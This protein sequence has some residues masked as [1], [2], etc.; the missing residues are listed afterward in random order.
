MNEQLKNALREVAIEEY[1]N[2]ESLNVNW[3][4]SERFNRKIKAVAVKNGYRTKNIVKRVILIAAVILLLSSTM[5]FSFADVKEKVINF[6]VRDM[7][8]HIEIQY[9]FDEAGDIFSD[10]KEQEIFTP[11]FESNGF[12]LKKR[13]INEHACV[14]VWEKGEQFIILQQG[15]GNTNR[16]VDTQ[17]LAKN[18]RTVNGVTYD[19]YSEEGYSLIL[20]NTDEYTFSLDCYCDTDAS[21]IISMISDSGEVQSEEVQT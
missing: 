19:V 13:E 1:F 10:G 12:V 21:E 20:W 7:K 15:D 8:D 2:I 4:P 17:R 16:F 6:F 14:T 9:G 18:S 5:F 11:D 3:E